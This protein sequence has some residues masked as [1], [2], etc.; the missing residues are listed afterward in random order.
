MTAS[1]AL[2]VGSPA[3][4]AALQTTVLDSFGGD[5]LSAELW[6]EHVQRTGASL[7]LTYDWCRIWWRHY[8]NGRR[9]RIYLF[10]QESRLVGLAPMFVETVRLGPIG[11]RTAKRVGADSAMAV[12][13]LPILPDSAEAVYRALITDL[14]GNEG[15][16]ALCFGSV[17]GDD[18]ALDTLRVLC[19]TLRTDISVARDA[20]TGVQSVFHLPSTFEAYLGQL[21]KS[22]RQNYRRQLRQLQT[23]LGCTSSIVTNPFEARSVFRTFSAM[24]ERQWQAEGKLGHFGDWPASEAFNRDLVDTFSRSGRIRFHRL[25]IDGEF[26]AIQYAFVIAG[27][28]NWRLTARVP[29]LRYGRFG[30]GVLGLVQLIDAMIAEGVSQI[31]G[32]VGHYDYKL[33]YG[34]EEQE[35]R[36]FVIIPSRRS[37]ALKAGLFLRAADLLHF[38]YYRIWFLRLAPRLGMPRRPLWRLWI[39]SRL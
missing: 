17:P 15:C 19:G 29:E 12:F 31:D 38:L 35:I 9:L 30:L 33:R 23:G 10:R 28:C 34:A 3:E 11:L 37:A 32:G 36:S 22:Q 24:H 6:D 20:P 14:V 8:G 1:L 5:G 27:H 13:S 2:T 39:R 21:G 7:Y 4:P 25:A 26:V 18:S 16:E